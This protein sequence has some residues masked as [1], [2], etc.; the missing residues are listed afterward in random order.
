MINERH[1]TIELNI[2][3][4]TNTILVART[5]VLSLVFHSLIFVFFLSC[6]FIPATALS[7]S[8]L[9]YLGIMI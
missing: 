2:I 3:I 1:G 8:V 9:Y 7:A 5:D 6:Q 4:L